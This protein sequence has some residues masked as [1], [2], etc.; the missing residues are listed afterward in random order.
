MWLRVFPPPP[1]QSISIP[2]GWAGQEVH[3]DRWFTGWTQSRRRCC[4]PGAL[5]AFCYVTFAFLS[6]SSHLFPR[7]TTILCLDISHQRA[8]VMELR[9]RN[10]ADT[11]L[12]SFPS[13][14]CF[15]SCSLLAVFTFVYLIVMRQWADSSSIIK[16]RWS[17]ELRPVPARQGNLLEFNTSGQ[18]HI[19]NSLAHNQARAWPVLQRVVLSEHDFSFRLVCFFD[20]LW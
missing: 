18:T 1:A 3:T 20:C 7:F 10:T 6:I 16:R 12:T 15:G 14:L 4:L 5:T 8:D 17:T 9:T 2:S 11:K 19:P 13:N